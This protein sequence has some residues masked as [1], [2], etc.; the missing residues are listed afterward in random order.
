MKLLFI[1]A[2]N[3]GHSPKGGEEYKNQV[4]YAKMQREEIAFDAVDTYLWAG[5]PQVWLKLICFLFF[6]KYGAILISASSVSTYR[7]LRLIQFI[8]PSLLTKISYLVIGGYFP[9][10]IQKGVFAKAVYTKLHRIIVEGQGMKQVLSENGI[11]ENIIVL[12]NFKAFDYVYSWS[13]PVSNFKFVFVGRISE[14]KGVNEIIKACKIISSDSE[15]EVHFY[16]PTEEN[17]ELD[18]LRLKYMGYLD[19]IGNEQNAYDTLANYDCMLFPTTWKGEGFP[20]VIIDAFIA[21]L[22]VIASD[23]NMNK[24]IIIDGVNGFVIEPNNHLALVDKMIFCLQNQKE[25]KEIRLVNAKEA[26]K[27]HINYLWDILIGNLR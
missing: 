15:F 12:P 22:P 19:F 2:I 20:G 27:Y 26:K 9:E 17:F 16:G 21:G 5:K 11:I 8:K 6:R 13:E 18:G 14:A 3:I 4:L 24:E 1:G 23:W 7:L 10:A 25:I